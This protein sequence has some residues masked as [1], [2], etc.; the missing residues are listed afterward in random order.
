MPNHGHG[1]IILR[2]YDE[3]IV[4]AGLREAPLGGRPAPT[5]ID[6]ANDVA[7][8][9]HAL[10]EIVC[11]FKSFSARRV[12]ECRDPSGAHV[13]QRNYYEH[14]IRAQGD[15]GRIRVY[16]QDHPAHWTSD[17]YYSPDESDR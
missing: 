8:K 13:W 10:P 6:N 4:G 2:G 15:V 12:N 7:L 9:R 17:S 11:A 1:V 14:V 5:A 16:I 3:D